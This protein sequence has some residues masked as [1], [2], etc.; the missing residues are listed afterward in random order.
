MRAVPL[1]G[2]PDYSLL[3]AVQRFRYVLPMGGAQEAG[4][5]LAVRAER[6]AL[7]YS[8]AVAKQP[9]GHGLRIRLYP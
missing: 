8:H 4:V 5:A 2:L 9:H 7:G 6:G 1:V 3:D